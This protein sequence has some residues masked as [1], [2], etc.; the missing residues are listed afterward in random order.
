MVF[1]KVSILYRPNSEFSRMVEEYVND[2]KRSRA[3]DIELIDLNTR[4][5]ASL[6]ALYGIVRYPGVLVTR[7][8]GQMIKDWQGE[9]LPLMSELAVYL[10]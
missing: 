8:D 9:H 1:M 2:F 6:A 4:E 7:D 10:G 3:K 5:G